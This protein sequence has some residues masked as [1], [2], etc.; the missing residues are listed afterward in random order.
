MQPVNM[1]QSNLQP[2][3]M[4]LPQSSQACPAGLEYLVD[5]DQVRIHQR[6]DTLGRECLKLDK[7]DFC[8]RNYLF[9][10]V[11]RLVSFLEYK[12]LKPVLSVF[13]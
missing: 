11:Q 13:S 6:L 12:N 10:F 4:P 9:S 7:M 1:Q 5:L 8:L 3:W 2:E